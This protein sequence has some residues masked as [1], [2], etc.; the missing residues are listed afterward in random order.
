MFKKFLW[1]VMVA[2]T[3]LSRPAPA[4]AQDQQRSINEEII[5]LFDK[6]KQHNDYFYRRIDELE[7]RIAQLS[8]PGFMPM[9]SAVTTPFDTAARRYS[10]AAKKPAT[11]VKKELRD[12]KQAKLVKATMTVPKALRGRDAL[13]R[14]YEDYVV[15]IE[16]DEA[17]ETGF[18]IGNGFILTCAH[19][20]QGGGLK[21]NRGG[22][23]HAAAA[24]LVDR[25]RDL[26]FL[27]CKGL[28]ED[29]NFLRIAECFTEELGEL[30]FE[31]VTVGMETRE[32]Q[33]ESKRVIAFDGEDIVLSTTE[34]PGRSGS[35]VFN[36]RKKLV[37]MVRAADDKN[38][39]AIPPSTIK[40]FME[41]FV[42]EFEGK[43]L[44][45]HLKG[46]SGTP[47]ITSKRKR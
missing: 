5:R 13:T 7:R 20:L 27:V 44:P 24:V 9:R 33:A 15:G 8:S 41:D 29:G 42:K 34:V 11:L 31:A 37:G 22:R 46:G 38:G 25:R 21:V 18:Y 17:L 43:G 28:I 14:A 35:P 23:M 39:Y 3:V 1:S 30:P 12:K 16:T 45:D 2:A 10:T 6:Q 47:E 36:S 26:A 40:S 19:G 4:Q 32:A